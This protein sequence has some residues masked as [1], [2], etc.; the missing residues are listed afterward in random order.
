MWD[1]N[2]AGNRDARAGRT[3]RKRADDKPPCALQMG[4]ADREIQPQ[5][6]R[7]RAAA[8]RISYD[9]RLA[10]TCVGQ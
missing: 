9:V 2:A 7:D 6:G 1:A 5:R 3:G 10:V 8:G 4:I